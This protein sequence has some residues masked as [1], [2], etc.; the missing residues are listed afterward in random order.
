[1]AK[2]YPSRF[3]HVGNKMKNAEGAFYDACAK[4]L[5]DSWT[6]L[7][8]VEWFG[9]R[10]QG[11]E[12]GDADF[13]LMN[14][15]YGIF[16]VEVKGGQRIFVKDNIWFTVPHGREEAIEISDPFNQAADSKSVLWSFLKE[17]IVGL[18]LSGALGHFVVFP[19]V[20]VSDDISLSAR[21]SLIC[22]KDSM[23]NLQSTI[24]KI[25]NVLGQKNVINEVQIEKIRKA[26]FPDCE[27]IS[28][29]QSELDEARN[30]M[31]EWTASQLEG[32]SMLHNWREFRVVGGAGTGKTSLAFYRARQLAAQGARILYLCSSSSA[33]E[34]LRSLLT[35]ELKEVLRIES[36][37]NFFDQVLPNTESNSQTVGKK[38]LKY[39]MINA[40]VLDLKW[41]SD[42]NLED[43]FLNSA[44]GLG[45]FFDGLIIDE[46]QNIS[47]TSI[48]LLVNLLPNKGLRY[49]Y[50]F[51]DRKQNIFN[52]NKSALDFDT[53]NAEVE[54]LMNCRSTAEIV[55]AAA[56][57]LGP[58][59]EVSGSIGLM[60]LL[61]QDE[62]VYKL[63][64][65][66]E[67]DVKTRNWSG[68]KVPLNQQLVVAASRYL[69]EDAGLKPTEIQY[70]VNSNYNMSRVFVRQP[71]LIIDTALWSGVLE[72][73]SGSEKKEV[74]S[75][76]FLLEPKILSEMVGLESDGLIVEVD[77]FLPSYFHISHLKGTKQEGTKEW[78][79]EVVSFEKAIGEAFVKKKKLIDVAN[80]S[81]VW[82]KILQG[83][84]TALYS[85]MSRAR[86][87]VVIIG[88]PQTLELVWEMLGDRCESLIIVD[89]KSDRWKADKVP[90]F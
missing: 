28:R 82:T 21:K 84:R 27:L 32:F 87:A 49:L 55:A 52:V 54:L 7:Y 16:C 11:N 36:I 18:Q 20:N 80:N 14:S 58:K 2:M 24:E 64:Q 3:P 40:F 42:K 5:D 74:N 60:P 51:G 6:V 61:L 15:K 73:E 34:Y 13:L 86:L 45:L 63:W 12:R 47:L 17:K 39:F 19:G 77:F 43:S 59:R 41:D 75:N 62:E 26:I 85:T 90:H 48:E 38:N 71:G 1:V 25:S 83:F 33:A 57:F 23:K 53:G 76:Q 30:L 8:E 66:P 50:I 56:C 79:A 9:R 88:G 67:E 69:I 4:Q 31:D 72:T 44:L 81:E 78:N 29:S 65:M 89:F 10:S 37:E 22:D 68:I 35:H 70:I 46:G